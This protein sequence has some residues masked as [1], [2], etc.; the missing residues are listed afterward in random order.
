MDTSPMRTS[1]S[2]SFDHI[3]R[4]VWPQQHSWYRTISAP[5][6]SFLLPFT[7]TPS[8][9]PSPT[10]PGNHLY[11]LH[12][13]VSFWECYINGIIQYV[14]FWDGLFT[15]HNAFEWEPFERRHVSIVCSFF[16]LSTVALHGCDTVYPLTSWL[17]SIFDDHKQGFYKHSCTGFWR[18]Y[19]F[20]S[21]GYIFVKLQVIP[22]GSWAKSSWTKENWRSS[23]RMSQT[24][25]RSSVWRC[26]VRYGV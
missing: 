6:A 11:V 14:T 10:N 19:V 7:A 22:V 16:L 3:C 26:A 25:G 18:I 13:T 2:M 4:L 17:F 1:S 21:L 9:C 20:I 8:C 12:L 24:F 5:R 23:Y 15:W